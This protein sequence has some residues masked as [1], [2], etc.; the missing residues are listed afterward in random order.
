VSLAEILLSCG[1]LKA[2]HLGALVQ[3]WLQ[4]M[5]LT[6]CEAVVAD[7]SPTALI[8]ARIAGLPSASVG[9]GFW[10]PPHA[11]PMPAFRDWEAIAPGRVQQAETTVLA[12]VN[13]VLQ[14]QGA[15]P[16]AQLSH[17]FGG[18]LPLMCSW[19]EIDHFAR[20]EGDVAEW[21][22]PNFLPDAGGPPQWPA[23]DGPRVFAYL[24]AA[25]PDHAAVLAALAALG[26]NVLCYLPEV[27]AGLKPPL[28]S[29]RISY[30]AA[31]VDLGQAF[32][33][34]DLAVC[35]AGQGTVA[36][37]LLGG[38]PLLMLPMQAEQFMMSRQVQRH[39]LGVNAAALP[40]PTDF[41]RLIGPLLQ[42]DAPQRAAALAFAQRHADFSHATQVADL[43]RRLQTL[44]T[45]AQ[46]P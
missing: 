32:A 34:A 15:A 44:P 4:A 20:P 41:S 38:V 39:G 30:A 24:K 21:L 6:R 16:L 2:E 35:H 12:N 18:D 1:Y 7:Y 40:R 14:G 19:P 43:V 29:P 45:G 26:A 23:A 42:P 8:A 33:Q 10:M 36:Q 28:V 46:R 13:R 22:G 27:T 25:H 31:P 5:R 37:A 9:M 11:Q 17:L 3:G